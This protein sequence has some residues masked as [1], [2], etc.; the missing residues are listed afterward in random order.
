V[1]GSAARHR[2]RAPSTGNEFFA[3]DQLV[4]GLEL[5]PAKPDEWFRP[6]GGRQPR[7]LGRFLSKQPVPR[8]LKA[9]PIVL[10]DARGILW[11]VGVRRAARAPVTETT[12][13]AL[14]VHVETP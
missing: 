12:Q 8:A 4:G 14:W 10:A 11:V 13:R 9:R 1:S 3:A 5:R 2:L 7:R 6:F